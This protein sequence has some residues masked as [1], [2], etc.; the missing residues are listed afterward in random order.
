MFR[1]KVGSIL[2]V[3][4]A[5]I[6]G[7]C[8]TD[9]EPRQSNSSSPSPTPTAGYSLSGTRAK[10][11]FTGPGA[12]GACATDDAEIVS[13]VFEQDVP[14][15]RCVVVRGSQR[16]RITNNVD[17]TV[18][19]RLGGAE[20]TLPPDSTVTLAESFSEYLEPGGYFLTTDLYSGGMEIRFG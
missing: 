9:T 18:I 3:L 17:Q 5:L 6:S 16:L 20:I 19:A 2:L 13:V 14:V 8:S 11:D 4:A 15:P 12:S 1:T 7:A 10:P